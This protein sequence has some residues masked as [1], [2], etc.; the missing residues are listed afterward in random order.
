[1]DK[2]HPS[3]NYARLMRRIVAHRWRIVV[4]GLLAVALP[5]MVWAIVGDHDTY[6]ASATLF[7][8]PEKT[9][10][11][12][13]RDFMTPE[14]SALYQVVLRSRSLAQA[15][16]ETL[17]KESR[18]ELSRQIGFRDYL[19]VAMNQLRRWRGQEVV[20]YSPTE[21]AVRELQSARMAFTITKEG[22]VIVTATAFSPRV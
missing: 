9:D 1:M 12:L 14:V 7:I 13:L 3:V 18:D 21:L 11:G 15:V 8:S 20:V 16:V 6:E 17:P 10:P 2:Q 4:A 5:T 19:L 22:T